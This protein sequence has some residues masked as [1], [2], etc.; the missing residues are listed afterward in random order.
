MSSTLTDPTHPRLSAA[1]PLSTRQLAKNRR[2]VTTK[3]LESSISPQEAKKRGLVSMTQGFSMRRWDF[4][5][6]AL[7]LLADMHSR[8][9]ER[10]ATL[11][12]MGVQ[13]VEIWAKPV[14]P[15][16]LAPKGSG[17]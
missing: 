6:R 11:V 9:P 8:A 1:A 7:D 17:I 16:K 13:L 3:A 12:L 10:E 5:S 14:P 2:E 15:R 4:A